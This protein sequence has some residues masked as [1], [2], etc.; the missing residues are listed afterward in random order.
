MIVPL[1][2]EGNNWTMPSGIIKQHGIL[3]AM[4]NFMANP[5]VKF[6]ERN[7]SLKDI[8]KDIET[9]V[10]VNVEVKINL[11]MRMKQGSVFEP[12]FCPK[13][14]FVQRYAY[15]GPFKTKDEAKNKINT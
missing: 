4:L 7:Q 10:L 11:M 6:V 15:V 12:I 8:G 5:N 9:I 14:I 3:N 13:Y 1:S 2:I